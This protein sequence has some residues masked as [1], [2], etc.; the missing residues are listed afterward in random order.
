MGRGHR[1]SSPESQEVIN[2]HIHYHS[3]NCLL[4]PYCEL[5]MVFFPLMCLTII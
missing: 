4:R 2:I 1:V 3:D 5:N